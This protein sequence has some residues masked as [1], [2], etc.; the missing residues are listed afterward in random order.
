M[1]TTRRRKV[2]TRRE[3]ITNP[4]TKNIIKRR[5]EKLRK[6]MKRKS[7]RDTNIRRGMNLTTVIIRIMARKAAKRAEVNMATRREVVDTTKL[8]PIANY[9]TF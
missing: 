4:H 1:N 7:T 5:R 2:N 6:D 9:K 8:N 3:D